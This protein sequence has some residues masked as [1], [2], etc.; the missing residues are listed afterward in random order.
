MSYSIQS[1]IGELL[2]NADARSVVEQHLPGMAAHPQIS[3]ARGMSL[4]AVAPFSGNLITSDA[5]SKI[6]IGL[7]ALK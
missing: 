2:D 1:T 6:D 4:A 3:M 5:L 7:K